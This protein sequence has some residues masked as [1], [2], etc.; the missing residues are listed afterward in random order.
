MMRLWRALRG[1]LILGLLLG[2]GYAILHFVVLKPVPIGVRVHRV[3]QGVVE[4]I[5]TNTKA[6]SVRARQTAQLTADSAGRIVAIGHREGVRVKAG[7]ELI[8]L[9]PRTAQAALA[10]AEK[11]LES[12]TALKAQ[13]AASARNALRRYQR[14]SRLHKDGSVTEDQLETTLTVM[15]ETAAAQRSAQ[16]RVEQQRARVDQAK[17]ELEKLTVRAPFDGVIT[18]VLVEVGEWAVPGKPLMVLFDPDD[19]YV[20][21][22]LD[23]VD[24]GDVR[25]GLPVRMQ[26]DPFKDMVFSGT[27]TRVAA[28]VSEALEQNRTIEVEV[29]FSEGEQTQAYEAGVGLKQG[30]SVDVEVILEQTKAAVLRVPTLA[31]MEGNRVLVVE[32]ELASERTITAGLRNWEYTQVLGGVEAGA[33]VIVSLDREDVKD[34]ALVVIDEEADR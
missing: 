19:L 33:P 22:E 18:A 8:R 16:A 17:L 26:L 27:I 28:S 30:M 13:A 4:R 7:Q 24:I 2:G 14:F 9:D 32:G 15:E 10:L 1:W 25:L 6:G 11:E 31:L 12:A 34:G 29:V 21:A 23:E 3:K 20:L 5:V